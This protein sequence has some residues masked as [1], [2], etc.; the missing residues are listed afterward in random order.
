MYVVL[1]NDCIYN[2]LSYLEA[3]EIIKCSL[4]NKQFNFVS[5]NECLWKKLFE[6]DFR[7]VKCDSNYYENYTKQLK[8]DIGI[9]KTKTEYNPENN[10]T[11]LDMGYQK[12]SHVPRQIKNLIDL[13]ILYLRSNELQ[14]MSIH[15]CKLSN[16]KTLSLSDNKLKYIP[17]EIGKL[18]QLCNLFL[19]NNELISLP[20]EIGDLKYLRCLMIHNNKIRILPKEMDNL[21]NLGSFCV[22]YEL[23][24]SIS[25]EFL[26][27]RD[28]EITYVKH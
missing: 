28:L 2:I 27:I 15:I 9:Y 10:I 4:I 6:I 26:N 3:F 21:R 7:H 22:D 13:N 23:K 17:P 12:I 16:L 11:C 24:A 1:D 25:N 8:R 14:T 5:K 20:T 19:D 18:K